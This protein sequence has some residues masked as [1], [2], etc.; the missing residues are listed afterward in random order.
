MAKN[1][2]GKRNGD[3]RGAREEHRLHHATKK[4]IV[5]IVFAGAALVLVLAQFGQAGPAGI[6]MY[7]GLETLLGAGYVVFPATL[8]FAAGVLMFSEG[9]AILMTTSLGGLLV[10]LSL[11]GLIEIA[12]PGRGGWVGLLLGSLRTPFGNLAATI[13]NS[14][15][16]L[17]GI[18]VAANAPLN[19]SRFLKRKPKE[20]I[21]DAVIEPEEDE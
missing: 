9:R 6:Y 4:S 16:L 19:F 14:V 2:N 3:D 10:L 18:L 8:L 5:A 1:K 13:L 15:F 11:L 7:K 21:G 17:V 12:L 20:E